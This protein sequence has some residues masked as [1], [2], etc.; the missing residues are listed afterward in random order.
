[1]SYRETQ[2]FHPQTPPVLGSVLIV[3]DNP[4]NLRVLEGFLRDSGCRVRPAL[5]GE[6]ALRAIDKEL[7]DIILLDIRMPGMSGYEVCEQLKNR[8]D[9]RAIPVIFISALQNVDDKIKAFEAGGVDYVVKPFQSEEVVSRVKTHLDLARTRFAL[10]QANTVL[11]ERVQQRTADLS[12]ANDR[13]TEIARQEQ[14][15][16]ELMRIALSR[17]NQKE[18][19]GRT[20][21]LLNE[22]QHWKEA[23]SQNLIFLMHENDNDESRSLVLTAAKHLSRED[24]HECQTSTPVSCACYQ[25][26]LEGKAAF[27]DSARTEC[28]L[29]GKVCGH[30][31]PRY[32]APLRAEEQ[33]LGALVHYLPEG[34][35]EESL[36]QPFFSR[37]A[38]VIALG[39]LR[40]L[41]D[42]RVAHQAF[43]D[44]LT[45]LPNRWLFKNR[46]EHA[47]F[48]AQRSAECG[49]ILFLDLDRFK[50]VN[51]ALGHTVGDQTL[52]AVAH[53][54]QDCLRKEDTLARWGGDEFLVLLSGLGDSETDAGHAALRIAEK[55][56]NR[57]NE[58]LDIHGCDLSVG[59]STGIALYS[60]K[61]TDSDDL[62]KCADTAMFRAKHSG[63]NAVQFFEPSM[64]A[65][66]EQ[67]LNL[68]RRLRQSI[69]AR[70][71]VLYYQPQTDVSGNLVGV[72]ALLRWPQADGG[73]IYPDVF[74][75]LAEE[76]GLIV[77][78]GKWVLQKSIEQFGQLVQQHDIP[79]HIMLAINV[80]ARQ[81]Q[82]RGLLTSLDEALLASGLTPR[83]LKLEVTES[84]LM[85]N[86]EQSIEILEGLDIRGIELSV[87]DFGT[88]YSSLTYLKKLPV[89]QLKID[90]SFTRGIDQ[91]SHDAVIVSAIISM[92]RN[93]DLEV[94]AEG[95]ET[96][97]ELQL[98]RRL[99]CQ[100]F[101]GY[102]FSHP[103]PWD[104]V[105]ALLIRGRVGTPDHVAP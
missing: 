21:D 68:E 23:E 19:L 7:P 62:I 76:T 17:S 100:Y 69:A 77:P 49:A 30:R 75:P 48:R 71:F 45:G 82:D 90:R 40:R 41:A 34:T 101:Q 8:E 50:N 42:E 59:V 80:S 35:P 26:I 12:V 78:L 14:V 104:D 85:Q 11:E 28:D 22:R 33:V 2:E 5:S 66:A 29:L 105:T 9:T 37:I 43:H 73:L 96:D 88:G 98:L 95:V 92:A 72:E 74:I 56:R 99:G 97:E 15:I 18:F 53:R 61:Q 87:D 93:L 27:H 84:V 24:W 1:M 36:D 83:R 52:M 103:L 70:E 16:N 47:L 79:P 67:I 39:L 94:L 4:N 57:I 25:S 65:E 64:Q 51:E 102:L 86:I 20:L 89:R 6:Q 13:L 46:L 63:R 10:Q 60:E 3:D 81:F 54:L 31:N 32:W 44:Q 38:E 58:P 55:I 91:D